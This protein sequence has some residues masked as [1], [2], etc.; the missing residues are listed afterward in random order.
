MLIHYPKTLR[1]RWFEKSADV[2]VHKCIVNST[3]VVS[4]TTSPHSTIETTC[5]QVN[6]LRNHDGTK[7][8]DEL[9][10]NAFLFVVNVAGVKRGSLVKDEMWYV[11]EHLARPIPVHLSMT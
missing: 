1:A 7:S 2:T 4:A 6:F 5:N 11:K 9:L 10:G 3:E 8:E